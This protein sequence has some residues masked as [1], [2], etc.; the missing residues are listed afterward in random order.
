MSGPMHLELQLRR[1]LAWALDFVER[2]TKA[3]EESHRN[4]VTGDMDDEDAAIDVR[5]ARDWIKETKEILG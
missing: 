1:Q 5:D 2:E 4:P 3:L